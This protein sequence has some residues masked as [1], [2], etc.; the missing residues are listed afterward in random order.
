[1]TYKTGMATVYSPEHSMKVD[2]KE[3]YNALGLNQG[4]LEG[5]AAVARLEGGKRDAQLKLGAIIRIKN[6]ANNEQTIALVDNSGRGNN[7]NTLL[8]LKTGLAKKLKIPF[9]RNTKGAIISGGGS[10][11]YDVLATPKN[12]KYLG[13]TKE[14]KE[15]KQNIKITRLLSK[16]SVDAGELQKAM[17]AA[18]FKY[19]KK[20]STAPQKKQSKKPSPKHEPDFIEWAGNGLKRLWHKL[21]K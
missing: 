8:D 7:P 10:I 16:P 6:K 13:A 9:Q 11:A 21:T 12:F 1:M 18:G 2:D 4:K 20:L 17:E 15:S 19:D 5:A 3:K 14:R